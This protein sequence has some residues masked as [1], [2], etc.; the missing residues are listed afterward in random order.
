MWGSTLYMLERVYED[1]TERESRGK[2]STLIK[3]MVDFHF[4]F[5]LHLMFKLLGITNTL[6]HTLQQK[7]QNIVNAMKFS[8]IKLQNLRDKGWD[9]FL[10]EINMFCNKHSIVVLDMED[11]FLISGRSRRARH[12]VT[13]YHHHHNEVFLSVIDLLTVEKN[14]R[15]SG[16]STEL[17]RYISCLDPR[18]SFSTFDQHS[19][20]CLA[21]LYSDDFSATDLYFLREKLDT[22]ICEMVQTGRHSTFPLVYR[23]IELALIL[24]VVIAS[25]ERDF[26]Q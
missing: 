6:L 12:W 8:K 11:Q 19:L 3:L 10:H 24:P 16:F 2:A 1:A 9:A 15:F 14:N 18:D 20:I 22:Y 23:L 21:K 4:V 17:L 13:C 7:D 5:I 25:V 26:L